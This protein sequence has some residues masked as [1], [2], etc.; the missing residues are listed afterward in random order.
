MEKKKFIKLFFKKAEEAGRETNKLGNIKCGNK[1][2]IDKKKLDCIYKY[3][4]GE[5][6][7]KPSTEKLK[8]C[9]FASCCRKLLKTIAKKVLES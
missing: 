4:K 1:K 5:N 2:S 8:E 3:L 7:R 9:K 6:Y